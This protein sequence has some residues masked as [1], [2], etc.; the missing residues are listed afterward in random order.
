MEQFLVIGDLY[1]GMFSQQTS[2]PDLMVDY[3]V[4][5]QIRAALP[6]DYTLP[7]Q[8]MIERLSQLK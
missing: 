5:N 7:D 1:N 6:S 3:R 8:W 2:D 4:W